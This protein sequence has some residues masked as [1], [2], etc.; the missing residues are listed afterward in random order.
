MTLT[1]KLAIGVVSFL[2]IIVIGTYL[3]TLNN[4][5]NYFIAQLQSHSQDTATS[6][7][8]SLSQVKIDDLPTI[9]AMV[10]AVFDRGYFE[11]IIVQD[12]HGK[13]LIERKTPRKQL[14][15]IDT[16][17]KALLRWPTVTQSALIMDGWH[18]KGEVFV[19]G[20]TQ[21]VTHLLRV[22]A[23]NLLVWYALFALIALV[24]VY[25]FIQ[26]V[27]RPLKRLTAQAL[28]ISAEEFV[29]EK[30]IPK[31]EELRQVTLAMNQM[32]A[33]IKLT[34]EDLSQHVESL[35]I[36][37]YQDELTQ[38][39]N[40][41]FFL[42]MIAARLNNTEDFIP[43]YLLL[44]VIEGLQVFNTKHGFQEGDKLILKIAH[45][46]V[47][48]WQNERDSEVARI[49]G[50]SFAIVTHR[51]EKHALD[52]DCLLFE[53]A[54]R[55][56]LIDSLEIHAF[57]GVVP[58]LQWQS[59]SHLLTNADLAVQ[60][61]YVRKEF[62]CREDTAKDADYPLMR[63]DFHEALDKEK[64]ILYAQGVT[65]GKEI[66]HYEIY[67]RLALKKGEELSAGLFM[68][69]AIAFG[70]DHLID[71]YVLNKVISKYKE[72]KSPLALNISLSTMINKS[73]AGEYLHQIESIPKTARA[74]I[75]LEINET[76]IAS[77]FVKVH[78]FLKRARRL[79]VG[80]GI[81]RVGAHFFP[82]HYLT[83]LHIDYIK[84]DGSLVQDLAK[85]PNK[86]FFIH[87]FHEMAKTLKTQVV[88][89]QIESAKQW[90][91]VQNAEIRWG[92]GQYL[93]EI[94]KYRM[95]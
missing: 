52:K 48:F 64:V 66:L 4:S 71:A 60:D 33:A 62:F 14:G 43:G 81:D 17:L 45:L 85:N 13:V 46:C 25:L 74:K 77:H 7:G 10:Q 90:T 61:A 24:L 47:K 42:D 39:P 41:R 88:A 21:Y 94:E 65:D 38:L 80:I 22:N 89:T 82:M 37:V 86:Q 76:F 44:L 53:Q 79:G 18:Q 20:D 69:A 15:L 32:V 9:L 49:N 84:L 40:R 51:R 11:K 67:A 59:P 3:I 34:F 2:L 58:Y 31:V 56:L 78:D 50:A 70:V 12:I 54:M 5:R 63:E 91:A 16:W 75:Y 30:K 8:L 29:I 28:A 95:K 23:I 36:Q 27:L 93:T 1:K 26:S 19:T 73:I 87:Y 35:R 6:L 68:P 92:Q 55:R 57:M 83:E 72:M